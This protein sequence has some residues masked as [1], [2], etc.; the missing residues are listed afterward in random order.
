[1]GLFR[2]SPEQAA[3]TIAERLNIDWPPDYWVAM[4]VGPA[5]VTTLFIVDDEI[6]HGNRRLPLAGTH[7]HVDTSGNTAIAQGWVVKERSDTRQCFLTITGDQEL[8]IAVL[9]DQEPTARRAAAAI[10]T[11]AKMLERSTVG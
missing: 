4:K 6:V 3:R 7:A 1:M 10:N 8:V 5:R 9:P 2:K 11:R